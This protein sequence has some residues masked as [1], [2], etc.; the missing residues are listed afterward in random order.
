MTKLEAIEAMKAGNKITHEYFTANQ[1][2]SL[3]SKGDYLLDD[4]V[5]IDPLEFWVYRQ[6][7]GWNKG[8]S[9]FK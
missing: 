1:W 6:G 4:E 2:M 5:V 8:W 3:D 9:I 7:S